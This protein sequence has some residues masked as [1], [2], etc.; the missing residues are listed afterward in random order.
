MKKITT[1]SKITKPIY[2]IATLLLI[3]SCTN[4]DTNSDN[5]SNQSAD[6]E[7]A[8]LTVEESETANPLAFLSTDGKFRPALLGGD[9]LLE[10]TIN[11]NATTVTYKD[12]VIDIEFYSKTNSLVGTKQKTFYE[13]I[14][15]GDTY[16]FRF[17]I[18]A[19]KGSATVGWNIV[20]ADIK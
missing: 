2:L 7:E 17:K 10:G 20:S 8:K 5:R 9:F 4:F 1:M 14:K 11:N 6:Y 16:N 19:P 18:W 3:N 12:I 15:P 13:F